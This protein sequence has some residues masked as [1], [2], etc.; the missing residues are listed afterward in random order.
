MAHRRKAAANDHK[1]FRRTAS[2][3]KKIN[4]NNK[5][6]RGGIRL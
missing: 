3:T 6:M 1:I 5:P 2:R 4:I